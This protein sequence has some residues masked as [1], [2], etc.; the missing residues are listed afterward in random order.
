MLFTNSLHKQVGSLNNRFM[1]ILSGTLLK[2]CICKINID[3]TRSVQG[4]SLVILNCCRLPAL[5]V[6]DHVEP[7]ASFCRSYGECACV[8]VNN[9]TFT[10]R[11]STTLSTIWFLVLVVV[12]PFPLWPFKPCPWLYG[13]TL[14]LVTDYRLFSTVFVFCV[15]YHLLSVRFVVNS[16][17]LKP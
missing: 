2:N 5:T 1:S 4:C 9:F 6:R 8:C 16:T 7:L 12:F 14:N 11:L 10:L 15:Y 3:L 17:I 13:R